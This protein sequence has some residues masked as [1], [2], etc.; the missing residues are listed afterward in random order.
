MLMMMEFTCHIN[1]SQ[2]PLR[3]YNF[4]DYESNTIL[5]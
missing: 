3:N 5:C 4:P 1:L 2:I